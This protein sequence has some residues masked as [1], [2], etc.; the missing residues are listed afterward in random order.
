MVLAV[1]TLA[2]A[3]E[4]PF[5]LGE[6]SEPALERGVADS[7]GS[8]KSYEVTG[9]YNEAGTRWTIDLEVTRGRAEHL[10]LSGAQDQLEVVVI[11]GQAYFRGKGFLLNHLGS[12]PVSQNLALAAGNAWWKSPTAAPP[13]MPDLT[14]PAS[15]RSTFLGSAVTRRT[16]HVTVDGLD[17]VRLSGQRANVYVS[18]AAPYR[19]VRL[20]MNPGVVIDGLGE[21]DLRFGN[22]DKDFFIT[23]PADVIDFSNLSSLPPVYTVM[24]VD[25]SGCTTTTCVVSAQL[26]NIGGPTG[27]HA[28]STVT[29][30]MTEA[31]SGRFI[32]RCSA[33]V[34]PDVGYNQTTSVSCS[35]F[36]IT[37]EQNAAVVTATV[38]N[39]GKGS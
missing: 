34:A 23:A 28:P 31:G 37:G 38:D 14:D 5:G 9:Y 24:S 13:R 12:D 2:T 8:A 25:T 29:F 6:P 22:Y 15:F 3:C 33:T 17:A 10:L 19:L 4:L 30:T 27:A 18:E 7:L 35:V 26:R 32:G 11:G 39:P 1:L 16:D 36:P 20:E 21:A